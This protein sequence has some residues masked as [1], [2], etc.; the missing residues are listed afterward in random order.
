MR[1]PKAIRPIPRTT[2]LRSAVYRP[3]TPPGCPVRGRSAY[4][5]H[6]PAVGI[7]R[8]RGAISVGYQPKSSRYWTAEHDGGCISHVHPVAVV[9]ARVVRP[10]PSCD[11]ASVRWHTNRNIPGP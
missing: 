2:V 10:A 9:I 8:T 11:V 4:R 6:A 7:D 1:L 5:C 3:G